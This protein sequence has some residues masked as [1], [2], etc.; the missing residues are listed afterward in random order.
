MNKC[1]KVKKIKRS[2]SFDNQEFKTGIEFHC[3]RNI[4][5]LHLRNLRNFDKSYI[6]KTETNK[7][8]SKIKRKKKK[9]KYNI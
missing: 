8:L 6:N 3:N 4:N 2:R 9:M 5:N 7:S 1:W